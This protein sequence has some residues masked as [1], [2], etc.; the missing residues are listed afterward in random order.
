M[1]P[2][3][4][5]ILRLREKW[6]L[7]PRLVLRPPVAVEVEQL[8][9]RV[10]GILSED[11]LTFLRCLGGFEYGSSATGTRETD[12]EGF[13]FWQTAEMELVS[14]YQ[15]GIHFAPGAE[16]F[17]LF[18]DYHTWCWAYAVELMSP[19]SVVFVGTSN[20]MLQTAAPNM[21]TS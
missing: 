13:R 14:T 21:A 4:E 9:R 8:R 16:R 12:D 17:L 1:S 6:A 19:N 5:A 2:I 18:A 7:D 15:N 11:L 20:G 10:G 3:D